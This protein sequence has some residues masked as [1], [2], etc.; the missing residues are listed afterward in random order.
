MYDL[1]IRNGTIIDVTGYD[2]YV[3]DIYKSAQQVA[4][5]VHNIND[6]HHNL[7]ILIKRGTVIYL[8]S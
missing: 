7:M 2:R 6:I 5:R 3:D 8:D 4:T 1:I